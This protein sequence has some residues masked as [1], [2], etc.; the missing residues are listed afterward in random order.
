M[1]LATIAAASL[2][3]TGCGTQNGNA[4]AKQACT[5]VNASI[6]LYD[7]SIAAKNPA[8]KMQ[9]QNEA[10]ERLQLALQPAA[11]ADGDNGQWQAL[12]ATISESSRVPEGVL[13]S[14]LRQQCSVADGS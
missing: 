7:S 12:M 8:K 11:L 9:L 1:A 4:L 6:A 10:Y 2:L 14:A 13:V 3:A 5:D